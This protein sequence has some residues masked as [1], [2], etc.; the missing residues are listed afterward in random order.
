MCQERS[1]GLYIRI[2]PFLA[3]KRWTYQVRYKDLYLINVIN[4]FFK[5]LLQ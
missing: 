2:S 4:I 5:N 1:P 3:L